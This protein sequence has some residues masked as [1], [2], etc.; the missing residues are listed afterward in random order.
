MVRQGG[1]NEPAAQIVPGMT[2][3][4]ATRQRQ[5]TE[6]W[7]KS[8]DDQ[9]NQIAGRALDAQRQETVGQIHNYLDGA[10]A[11]LKEGDVRR[12]STLAQKAY[13]LADDL[14]KH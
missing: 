3:A 4:E 1:A 14:V 5:N 13:L 11:A 10:R 2:L 7:L 8:T 12:A 9:L 6:Q